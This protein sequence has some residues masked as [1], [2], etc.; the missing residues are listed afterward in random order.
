MIQEDDE[1]GVFLG[2]ITADGKLGIVNIDNNRPVPFKIDT[3][4]DVTAI[5]RAD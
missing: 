5:P 1:D 4:L 2:C 3:G